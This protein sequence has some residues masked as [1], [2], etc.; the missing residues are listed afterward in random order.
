VN[1]SDR[2]TCYTQR[3]LS[4]I[5]SYE[6]KTNK[7]WHES[8]L[9]DLETEFIEASDTKNLIRLMSIHNKVCKALDE[10]SL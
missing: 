5:A 2:L 4:L 8:D 10:V 7:L 9:S 3:I 1:Q 6:I